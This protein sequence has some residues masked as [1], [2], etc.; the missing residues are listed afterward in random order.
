MDLRT[1]LP[2][3]LL[4]AFLYA[5]NITVSPVY[6]FFKVA[7][8]YAS[9]P[10]FAVAIGIDHKQYNI[11]LFTEEGYRRWMNGTP[12]AAVYNGVLRWGDVL[13][14]DVPPGRHVLA[15]YPIPF[16]FETQ[17]YIMTH[18]EWAPV[19]VVSLGWV[20]AEAVAGY[21]EIHRLKARGVAPSGKS[22]VNGTS[23]QLNAIVVLEL[24]DGGKQYYFVQNTLGLLTDERKYS[25]AVN[26][27]NYTSGSGY[28]SR[29]A[30]RGR[31]GGY[32]SIYAPSYYGYKTREER[33]RLPFSG[34]LII[35]VSAVEGVAKVDFGYNVGGGVVWYD[36]VTIKPYAPVEG[37]YIMAGPVTTPA[38]RAANVPITPFT[39]LVGLIASLELVLCGYGVVTERLGTSRVLVTSIDSRYAVL[40]EVDVRMALL[41]W[42]GSAWRPAPRI[43]NFGF[44]TEEEV[45]LDVETQLVN[46]TVRITKGTFKPQ[47]LALE[48][49]EPEIPPPHAQFAAETLAVDTYL[50]LALAAFIFA[51]ASGVWIR[52]RVGRARRRSFRRL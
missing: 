28:L 50:P 6:D 5:A 14:I 40:E 9:G 49:P 35:N 45:A 36:S 43:Y 7:Y 3:I 32:W 33:Y 17:T 47:L 2:I 21:F 26:I 44:N 31:G 13:I 20:K 4:S 8:K 11:T 48:P 42:N 24:A 19:G 10:G 37:A 29:D 46:G 52:R 27:Y 39:T 25:F 30:I 18:H 15:V 38:P 16:S 34:F 1:V 51:I 41:V 12:G 23:I 22:G